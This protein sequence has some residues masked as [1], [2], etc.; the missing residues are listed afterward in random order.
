MHVHMLC[1]MW[2]ACM[3]VVL[4][5]KGDICYRVTAYSLH[6]SSRSDVRTPNLCYLHNNKRT[7]A[8]TERQEAS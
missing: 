1:P 6:L 2:L 7:N 4:Q 3:Y 5:L 8:S